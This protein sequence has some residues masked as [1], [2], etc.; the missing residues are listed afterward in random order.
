MSWKC[1]KD[2]ILPLMFLTPFVLYSLFFTR[3]GRNT[4]LRRQ[5]CNDVIRKVWEFSIVEKIKYTIPDMYYQLTPIE[6]VNFL[7]LKMMRHLL[8]SDLPV[9]VRLSG[10]EDLAL[11]KESNDPILI[12]LIHNYPKVFLH[13][14]LRELNNKKCYLITGN[15]DIIG[16]ILPLSKLATLGQIELI[17]NDNYCLVT[18]A[19]RLSKGSA[20]LCAVNA[21]SGKSLSYDLISPVMF[22]FAE[23]MKLP[24]YFTKLITTRD[25]EFTVEFKCSGVCLDARRKAEDYVEFLLPERRFVVR[26]N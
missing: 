16:D 3:E 18:L 15:Q 5:Q 17:K 19:K 24:V 12:V 9:E 2:D 11:I 14:I 25:G 26:D 23:R 6:K 20:A 10:L 1:K 8:G 13:V 22:F 4:S 21:A 7:I